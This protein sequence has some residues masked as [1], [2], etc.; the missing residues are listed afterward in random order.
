M[1]DHHSFECLNTFALQT[2]SLTAQLSDNPQ[3]VNGL[4]GITLAAFIQSF[5]CLIAGSILGLAF[6]WK[7]GLVAI[8]TLTSEILLFLILTRAHN[9]RSACI[10]LLVSS[11]YIQLVSFGFDHRLSCTYVYKSKR[12]VVMKDQMNKKAH[13]ESA[14]LACEAAG[15]IRT[16]ASLTREADCLALYSKS[17]E[18]PLKQ[19]KG[20]VVWANL[21]YA[22]SQGQTFWVIALVFWYGSVLVSRLEATTFQF[23]VALIVPI[24]LL[25]FFF[26]Y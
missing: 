14:Q 9:H 19:S 18:G 16:V 22:F 3:K 25:F 17:L 10:P 21:L 23:F 20:S 26:F 1:V 11:G 15:S 6:I 13:A 12:V 7:V 24:L 4:A 2:G 8:G 5:S